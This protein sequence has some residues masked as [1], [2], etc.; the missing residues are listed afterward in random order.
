M[1]SIQTPIYLGRLINVILG[2]FACNEQY[3]S[4]M[5]FVLSCY[6]ISQA[7]VQLEEGELKKEFGTS[8]MQFKRCMS[9]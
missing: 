5:V 2:E 7:D 9:I 6:P 4:L 1:R 3:E 8:K